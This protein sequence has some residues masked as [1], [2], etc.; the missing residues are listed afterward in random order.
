[1]NSSTKLFLLAV[2]SSVQIAFPFQAML[3]ADSDRKDDIADPETFK[4]RPKFVKVYGD[5]PLRRIEAQI[6]A[7]AKQNNLDWSE[8][9]EDR[10]IQQLKG[11]FEKFD[12]PHALATIAIWA[13]MNREDDPLVRKL[14]HYDRIIE[15]A[16][17]QS[18]FRISDIGG[19]DAQPALVRIMHQVNMNKDAME[20]I[21]DCLDTVSTDGYKF[22]KRVSVSFT[23]EHLN[24][25]PAP[26]DVAQFVIPLR[27]SLWKIWKSPTN[28]ASDLHARAQFT[29]NEDLT[30][31]NINVKLIIANAPKSILSMKK[32]YEQNARKGLLRLRITQPLPMFTKNTDVIVDF[33]GP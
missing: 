18:M 32:E 4:P 25:L 7:L 9:K 12:R 6:I 29:V 17:Y 33:Y 22:D 10:I 16:F 11:I 13:W 23:D 20:K 8:A 27:D 31:S 19:E 24:A 14:Y 2:L 30:I 21:R 5:Q 15:S 1:M 26:E 3:A 28:I